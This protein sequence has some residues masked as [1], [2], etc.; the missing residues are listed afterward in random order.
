METLIT[1][2]LQLRPLGSLAKVFP[3]R[4]FG[5]SVREAHAAHGQEIS[6]QVAYRMTAGERY[7]K[8]A[9]RVEIDS[10]LAEHAQLYTVQTVPSFLPSYPDRRDE[11]Y[12]THEPGLFPDPLFP[13]ENSEITAT[14]GT[15]RAVWISV[16]IP[17]GV[18]AGTYPVALHFTSLKSGLAQRVSFK[19][20]V[21]AATLPA[22]KTLFT[23]WF[24][25]DCIADAHGVKVLSEEHWTLIA[26]YMRLAAEHGMNMILTPVLTPP[27]DTKVGNERPT[28]QLVDIEKDGDTYTF[29]FA[30]LRRFVTLARSFGIEH[31]EINPMFTQWGAKSAPKVVAR[32]NGRLKKIFGWKT[33]SHGVK[34]AR[35]LRQL[36]PALIAEL[37]TLGVAR[38]HIYFHLSDEPH[39]EHLDTYNAVRD[40]LVPLLDGCH[41]LDALSSIEF[42]QK[43][44]VDVP[45]V[46]INHI[47]PWLEAR[48]TNM[49]AYYCC[50]QC[51]SVPNRFF[52]M[53]SA[54]NR[55]IGVLLFKYNIPGFL[56]WGYNFYY[57]QHSLRKLDPFAVTDCDAAF[58]SGDAF[59]VYPHGDGAI[60]SLRQKVFG[61]ALE[62]IRLLALLEERLGHE[63]AV[64]EIERVAGMTLTFTDYPHNDTFFDAL[65]EMIFSHLEAE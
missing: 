59:S 36:I 26:T 56:Q 5:A 7:H 51:R 57:S 32:V 47:D 48:V 27:L 15:W 39:L 9:Y 25:C 31:F 11:H 23:Q 2:K 21:H 58:P 20:H 54:R 50:S 49:W 29:D 13:V 8:A 14:I 6:F 12:L 10:P 43:G 45:V 22:Q 46:A 61:N 37:D 38:D 44:L 62:D 42:Y 40:I 18:A 16:R 41:Q 33:L 55:I 63:R 1:P 52:A 28:V 53:P 24:H 64:A 35:F 3:N 34:Y 60:P 17:D 65:Y 4:I 30:N 19:I